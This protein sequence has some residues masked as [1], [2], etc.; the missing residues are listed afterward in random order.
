M[1]DIVWQ[2]PPITSAARSRTPE[3]DDFVNALKARPGVWALWHRPVGYASAGTE[4]R[5]SSGVET[6][7]RRRPDGKYDLYVRWP[8][9]PSEGGAS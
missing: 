4:W 2:D 9:S 6:A 1:K 5:R 8:A 3:I 7:C